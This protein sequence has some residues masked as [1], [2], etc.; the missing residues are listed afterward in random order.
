MSKSHW[1]KL[2][3][4]LNASDFDKLVLPLVSKSEG[5]RL[6]PNQTRW[7]NTSDES[8]D[9]EYPTFTFP[10]EGKKLSFLTC[11]NKIPEIS[12]VEF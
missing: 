10:D 11:I 5:K 2:D 1:V 12:T 4:T 7:T 6:D 3:S 8:A 9:K